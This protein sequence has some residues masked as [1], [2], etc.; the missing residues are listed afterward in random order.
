[1]K[2]KTKPLQLSSEEIAAWEE[3]DNSRREVHQATF[4]NFDD[5]EVTFYFVTP[6]RRQSSAIADTFQKKGSDASNILYLNTCL[7]AGPTDDLEYDTD[8][9]YELLEAFQ[10]VQ[11]SKKKR[12]I[13]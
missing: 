1:M 10:E 6:N 2:I 8:L 7:L 5:D 11:E 13:K 4:L 12:R 9:F 3:K